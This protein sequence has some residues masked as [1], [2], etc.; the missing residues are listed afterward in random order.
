MARRNPEKEVKE[1]GLDTVAAVYCAN[2]GV[3]SIDTLQP[4]PRNPNRHPKAQIE[5]LAKI[6][7]HQGW[8]NPVVV[9]ARSGFVVKGHARIEAAKILGATAVPVD[10]QKYESE[11][12]EWA[13]MVADNKIAELAQTDIDIVRQLILDMNGAID[14]D[15]FGIP[16]FQ[17]EPFIIDDEKELGA[18]SIQTTNKCPS[19][20]YEW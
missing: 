7:R 13:D 15:L 3:V 18:E 2:T 9:S 5:L 11:A 19:C 16:D 10:L 17:I 8:R 14:I 20:F 1:A 12:Q 4:N 6:I